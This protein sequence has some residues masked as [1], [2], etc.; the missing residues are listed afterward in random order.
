MNFFL[1]EDFGICTVLVLMKMQQDAS[2]SGTGKIR[3]FLILTHSNQTNGSSCWNEKDALKK[4]KK[5][6]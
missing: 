5:K 4:K 2:L 3:T 1:K 6:V